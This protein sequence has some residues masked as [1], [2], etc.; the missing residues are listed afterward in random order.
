MNSIDQVWHRAALAEER[1]L[2]SGGGTQ[3]RIE[4]QMVGY[5]EP[6]WKKR[7]LSEEDLA[8]KELLRQQGRRDDSR[9]NLYLPEPLRKQK[10]AELERLVEGKPWLR[11]HWSTILSHE[12]GDTYISF[13]GI[14]N[15]GMDPSRGPAQVSS[16]E[17]FL[18]YMRSYLLQGGLSPQEIGQ[19]QTFQAQAQAIVDARTSKEESRARSNENLTSSYAD[20]DSPVTVAAAAAQV[21]RAVRFD[22][23]FQTDVATQHHSPQ[24]FT[25]FTLDTLSK[26]QRQRIER[27]SEATG[28]DIMLKKLPKIGNSVSN[29][30]CV[31]NLWLFNS[32]RFYA[33]QDLIATAGKGSRSYTDDEQKLRS[34]SSNKLIS[35][36]DRSVFKDE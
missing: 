21:T 17:S 28:T 19:A 36:F 11:M 23:G 6:A 15:S 9:D 31:L 5:K 18:K 7:H 2:G 34:I 27:M 10:Q 35:E 30:H 25:A 8:R 4:R 33:L 24:Y 12:P 13:T 22:A 14:L 32:T 3:S 1:A 26:K 20:P 29:M 16:E